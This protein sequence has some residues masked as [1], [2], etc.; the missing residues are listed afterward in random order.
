MSERNETFI[1]VLKEM[2]MQILRDFADEEDP[3]TRC[4][5]A[6]GFLEIGDYLSKQ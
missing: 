2:H 6:K 5:L 3:L 4:E 1:G